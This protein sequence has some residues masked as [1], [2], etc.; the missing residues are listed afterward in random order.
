MAPKTTT[1]TTTNSNQRTTTTTTQHQVLRPAVRRVLVGVLLLQRLLLLLLHG[2]SQP[3]Q[4]RRLCRHTGAPHGPAP[5]AVH[6]QLLM[7]LEVF[8][9]D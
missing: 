5:A 2:L 9:S 7:S 4:L 6:V 8:L 3:P 1:T